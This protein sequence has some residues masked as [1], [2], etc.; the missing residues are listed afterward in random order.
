MEIDGNLKD[1]LKQNFYLIDGS[2]M[3]STACK[4]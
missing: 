2:G 3:E 1:F 4:S